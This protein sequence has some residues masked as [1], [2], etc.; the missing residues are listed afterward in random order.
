MQICN[1][2]QYYRNPA[3]DIEI[4]DIEIFTAKWKNKQ[5]FYKQ[6][7]ITFKHS[8]YSQKTLINGLRIE[9]EYK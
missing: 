2:E 5:K 4:H 8:E 9:L 7:L 1:E 3:H 6:G